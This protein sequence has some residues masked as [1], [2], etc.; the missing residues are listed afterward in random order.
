M[1]REDDAT[2]SGGAFNNSRARTPQEVIERIRTHRYLLNVDNESEMVREGARH[3]QKALNEALNLLSRDLYSKKSHFVLELVQNAD[4]NEYSRDVVPQLTFRV[5]P[6]QFIAVNNEV[7][8]SEE[9]VQ[10]ICGVGDSSKKEKKLGY[11]GEKGIGFKS[12]FMVSNAPQIHSNGYHFRFDRT[13]EANLLGYV[14]PEWCQPSEEVHSEQTT[15]V[16]PATQDYEFSEQTLAG[17]DARL[18]LFLRKLR[19]LT[20]EWKGQRVVYRRRDER[21]L[22]YLTAECMSSDGSSRLEENRYVRAEMTFA[23]N[24]SPD[25][26]RPD[27]DQSSVVLAFPVD[28][29]GAAKPELSSHVSAFLPVRQMGFKFE[30]QADF[31]LSSSREDI[32]TDRPWNKYLKAAIAHV[33]VKAVDVFK[34]TDALAFSFLK[35]LPAEG[36]VSDT[37]FKPLG[38]HIRELLQKSECLPSA[39]GRWMIPGELRLAS[40]PFRKLFPSETAL[41][42]FGFDYVDERVQGGDD[43]IRSLGTK[44]VTIPDVLTVFKHHGQWLQNQPLAWRAEFYAYLADRVKDLVADGLLQCACLPT[45]DG[46]LVVPAATNV[47]FPLSNGK[48]YGFEDE[49]VFVD[50]DLFELARQQSENVPKLF[51]ALMVR[52]DDP[53]DLVTSHILPRHQGESWKSSGNKALIGHLRYVKEKLKTYL[54]RA[55]ERGKSEAQAFQL[56]RDGMWVGTK[57]LEGGVWYFDRATNLYVGREYKPH[58]CME[59]ML[60]DAL[61]KGNV[62]SEDYLAPKPKDPDAEAESWREFFGSLGLR[63]SPALKAAGTDW[64]CS[65]E[66]Q[67]LLESSQSSVR[68]ATLECI[69]MHWA[70]YSSRLT[71][72]V[73]YSRTQSIQKVT[74][75]LSSL[76]A[77]LVPTRKKTLVSLTDSFYPTP[78]IRDLMGSSLPYIEATLSLP[79]LVACGIT[80]KVDAKAL[81]KRLKQLKS[82]GGDTAKQLHAIYRNLE[83]LWDTDAVYIKQAFLTDA[84]IRTKG[85]HNAWSKPDEVSWRSNGP[86]LDSLYPP[87]EGQY[88]D[89]S[90]FFVKR[91]GVPI[92]FP[93]ERRVRALTRLSAFEPMEAR[94][95][96]AFAIYARANRDLTAKP[97]R[98]DPPHP[99]WLETFENEAVFV[100]HRDEMVC[101][102]ELLFANDAPEI[103]VLFGDDETIS[104]LGVHSAELPRLGRLL[105]AVGVQ[106]LSSSAHFTVID[107]E[108][109]V[110]DTELTSRVRRSLPF[111]ARVLY[112]KKADVFERALQAGTFIGFRE[113]KVVQ[114]AQVSLSVTLGDAIRETSADIAVGEGR[115]LYR[116]GVRAIKDRLAAKLCTFLGA[117]DELA[118]TFAR[119]L[120]EEDE[121]SVEDFLTIRN[122]GCLPADLQEAVESMG[123]LRTEDVNYETESTNVAEV[124]GSSEPGEDESQALVAGMEVKGEQDSIGRDQSTIRASD[125]NKATKPSPNG[126]PSSTSRQRPAPVLPIPE[127]FS[128]A[129]ATAGI[130][131][132]TGS[133]HMPRLKESESVKSGSA[134]ATPMSKASERIGEPAQWHDNHEHEPEGRNPP[135]RDGSPIAVPP[136]AQN[137]APSDNSHSSTERRAKGGQRHRLQTKSGRLLSYAAGPAESDHSSSNDDPAKVAAREATAHAAVQYFMTTQGSRWRSL[138]EMP[139]NNPGFDVL[140]I[141]HNG[142]EEFIEVKGQSAAWAL[143]GIGLTPTE[144]MASQ[145]MGDKYWLCVVEHVHDERRRQLYLLRNPYGQTQQFRFDSGWKSAAISVEQVPLRPEKNMFIEIPAI[146]RGRIQ[147]VRTKGRFFNLHVILEDGRQINKPFN[148]A[149][150]RLSKE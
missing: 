78:E 89:F 6:E 131:A 117:P 16:L 34:E 18:L 114:V 144:L 145:Q 11:I 93:T 138:R 110:L 64:Q 40:K 17:L 32:L 72:S 97:G 116:T 147:S 108:D 127:P 130:P 74:Q 121:A 3:L 125:G 95:R 10:K 135:T 134:A 15:I 7:G 24:D 4:D 109:E 45:A 141:T 9:N 105:D 47:F 21:R 20:V 23:M 39:S 53:Y 54:E 22:S 136:S 98:D 61:A 52:F 80:Y 132:R 50:N 101:N 73:P 70:T 115:V 94:R 30:I 31:I 91:L 76:R 44:A 83:R 37:F 19:D 104:L 42:L 35:Y 119:V 55:A 112:A 69:D 81:V 29:N 139:P 33:F 149:T 65:E 123:E 85:A 5:T 77:T 99:E 124:E 79:M 142:E 14:I 102:D 27:V 96:E 63:F 38:I 59:S 150:M 140:A 146:G 88:G 26:K 57:R 129:M 25:E 56:L 68:K 66:L 113:L 13:N 106:R 2:G 107:A 122:I 43:L 60:G 75:F 103:A 36:D 82:E 49:M 8:F 92:D 71:F 84:L 126:S 87:L 111:F 51:A 28:A 46:E 118:D 48:R 62:V 58:F 12:V 90:G 41:D 86:F 128:P 1:R 120:M 143:E 137:S 100:N 148:P 67:L 133:G